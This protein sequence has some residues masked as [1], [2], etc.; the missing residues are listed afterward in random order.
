MSKIIVL[1]R[2]LTHLLLVLAAGAI[3][4]FAAIFIYLTPKLPD[5]DTLRDIRLQTPLRIYSRD[6]K[7]IGEFGEKK[8]TPL[9]FEDIPPLFIKAFLAAEDDRFYEHHGVDIGGLLRAA[10]QLIVSGEIQTGGSTIT[11]QVAKNYF[12]TQERTFSR[13]FNEIFLAIKIERALSKQE[14]LELYLNKIFLG[15]HAYGIEAAAGVYYDKHVGELTLAQMAMIAG[16]PKAPSAYNPLV[17]ASR[18]KSRRDWILARM[19]HLG[20]IDE[21]AYKTARLSEISASYYGSKLQAEAAYVSEMI[22]RDMIRRFGADAYTEGYR[23][24]ATIDSELQNTANQA[25]INGVTEYDRRHGYRGPEQHWQLTSPLDRDHWQSELRR[26]G[27]VG[28]WEPALVLSVE[29]QSVTGLMRDG[30]E[31]EL[32]WEDGL[33]EARPYI[34]EDSR[35]DAPTTAAD[36][37]KRGDVIRVAAEPGKRWQLSQLPEVQ[38]SLVSMDADTGAIL[39]LVGGFDYQHSSFNRVTQANRQP[40]SNFKPF[41]YAA[42]L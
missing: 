20:Y 1:R 21:E 25:V 15:N 3:A 9:D 5:V 7:L 22:R 33:A 17:N 28:R 11:M 39:S 18:A 42:A 26:L 10:S 13:K 41:V 31:I 16:L 8:R 38:A 23:A 35:G 24:Y 12:L 2:V 6:Q 27:S 29:D 19:L 36:I 30:T 14:I 4:G 32:L 37:L 40:G 34:N